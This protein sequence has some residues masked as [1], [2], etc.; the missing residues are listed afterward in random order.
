MGVT[1]AGLHRYHQEPGF[2]PEIMKL[3]ADVFGRHGSDVALLS[4][5][6]RNRARL[7]AGSEEQARELGALCRGFEL[8][9]QRIK[10]DAARAMTEARKL[11]PRQ[12]HLTICICGRPIE[13][14][15][16]TSGGHCARGLELDLRA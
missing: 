8:I 9:S 3:L 1:G 14:G 7:L 11:A 4:E 12:E 5:M 2:S 16:C 10:L 6:L 15:E 13:T